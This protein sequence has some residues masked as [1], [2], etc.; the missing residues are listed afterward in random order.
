MNQRL[1]RILGGTTVN[2]PYTLESK[3]P[4]ILETIMSLWDED[5]I[6]NYFMELMVNDRGGRS[7]FPPDVAAEIM[8]LSLVHASQE[9]PDKH[10]DI[11]DAPSESFVNFTPHPANDWADPNEPYKTELQKLDITCT[12][13]GFF[14]ATETG[15]RTAVALFMEAKINTEI[16]DNRGWTPLMM[17]A[18]NGHEEIIGLLI[19]HG[20]DVNALDSGGNSALHWAAFGGHISCAKQLVQHHAKIDARNNFGWTPLMQ[21]TARNHPG[22][23][24]LL[25]DSGVNLDA[26][27]DDGYTALH[28]AAASGYSEIVQLLLEQGADKNV[29]TSD[30]D[31]PEKLAVR[32]RQEAVIKLFGS[33]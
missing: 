22:I 24:A 10:K 12:P 20:A 25:V 8:H 1:I 28:K 4:R 30:G 18:F 9:A 21:A 15:N 14:E 19:Q 26:A 11:W 6:D 17:A 13:E 29:K 23:V 32:N 31:T 3:Y 16:R 2:Y 7:G 33:R 27:A 5:E